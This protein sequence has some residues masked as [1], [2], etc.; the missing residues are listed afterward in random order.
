MLEHTEGFL[1]VME[2]GIPFEFE[3]LCLK[4]CICLIPSYYR[5]GKLLQ[6]GLPSVLE[7][8]EKHTPGESVASFVAR[9]RSFL[10]EFI[11]SIEMMELCIQTKKSTCVL[12]SGCHYS[13]MTSLRKHHTW[14]LCLGENAFLPNFSPD[15][16]L[17]VSDWSVSLRL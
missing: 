1:V 17:H 4:T 15:K 11:S 10:F 6:D 12:S 8:V 16:H 2:V 7:T 14:P 9:C 13:M 5:P 3:T